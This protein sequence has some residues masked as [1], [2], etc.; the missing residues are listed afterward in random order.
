MTRHVGVLAVAVAVVALGS[1]AE[2]Q[3]ATPP[4]LLCKPPAGVQ[5]LPWTARHGVIDH[6]LQY[7]AVDLATRAQRNR[8]RG[9]LGK[10]AAA[11]DRAGWRRPAV[12]EGA[13]YD[14]RTRPR[15][16]GDQ[17]VYFFHAERDQERR[18]G[19]IFDAGRPKALIYANAPGHRL[20][21]VG[22]MWSTRDGELGPTPAGPILRWHSHIVC[23]QGK[24]RGLK[25]LAGGRCPPG[26]RLQQGASEML[27]VWFTRDLRSAFAISAP[28]PELCAIELLPR[29]SCV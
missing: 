16:A 9:I 1:A 21:L 25:P 20:I 14:M 7:P 24:K 12:A 6:L 23:K 18:S 2:A 19:S 11:A 3:T 28:R 29:D 17:A 27:H 26:S 22:A 8:A 5:K 15:R 10:L 13:G 4:T